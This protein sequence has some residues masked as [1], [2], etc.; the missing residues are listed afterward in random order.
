[1]NKKGRK[2]LIYRFETQ[3]KL[4]KKT[5][6]TRAVRISLPENEDLIIFPKLISLKSFEISKKVL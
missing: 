3:L 2:Q 5:I 4:K 6:F 1:M